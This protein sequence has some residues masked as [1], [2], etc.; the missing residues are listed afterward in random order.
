[1]DY[2]F[3]ELPEAGASLPVA[4]G[5]EW[6]R[7]PLPF[8]LDHVNV[9]LLEDTDGCTLVD[10]GIAL[11]SVKTCWEALLAHRQP[12]RLVVTHFHPDHLGLASWLMERHGLPLYMTLGEYLT[13]HAARKEFGGV[14]VPAMLAQFLQHGLDATRHGA[15]VARGNA[16]ARG[17][18]EL[19]DSFRRIK[20]FDRLTIGGR[21]W[22]VMTGYGHSPEHA[23]FYCDDLHV[24]ISGD[25]LLPRIS[26]NVS[27]F[28]HLPDADPL[29]DFLDS[30]QRL[31][32]LPEDTLVLPSHGRPFRNLHQRVTQLVAHHAERCATLLAS[33]TAPKSACELL[34]TLF[35]RE[36]DT[37]QVQFAMGETIAHLNHLEQ[38]GSLGRVESGDGIVRFTKI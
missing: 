33:C 25:M 38:A 14:G 1:M 22:R 30:L 19:P 15:L 32:V 16:Y 12:R 3:Q 11:P 35:P 18:P 7:M 26:T 2:P 28:A 31:T 17:V 13:A 10:T 29:Q 36:L 4:P 20:D 9:W 34:E 37:H 24:L 27:V 21:Q 8:A 6:V 5:V 23:S